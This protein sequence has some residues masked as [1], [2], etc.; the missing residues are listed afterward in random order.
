MEKEEDAETVVDGRKSG[1]GEGE[2]G[3]EKEVEEELNWTGTISSSSLSLGAGVGRFEFRS[4]AVFSSVRF[5]LPVD[6]P[7]SRCITESKSCARPRDRETR[8]I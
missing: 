2:R 4:S 8:T 7:G 6:G 5:R 3:V 1:K